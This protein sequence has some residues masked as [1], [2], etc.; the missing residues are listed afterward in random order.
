METNAE[1]Q[2]LTAYN[3]NT[4]A[5]CYQILTLRPIF[6]PF[7]QVYLMFIRFIIIFF[8]F[9]CINKD[10]ITN[11]LSGGKRV[12]RGGRCCNKMLFFPPLSTGCLLPILRF[13]SLLHRG[14]AHRGNLAH[15][16]VELA[17]NTGAMAK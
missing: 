5:R 16:Q 2:D 17:Q 1:V 8:F 3:I 4:K 12:L 15:S 13:I 9:F 10:R 14:S 11:N 7:A 6:S